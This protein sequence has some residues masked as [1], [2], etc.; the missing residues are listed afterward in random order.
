MDKASII[1]IV[2]AVIGLLGTVLSS[3]GIVMWFLNRKEKRQENRDSKIFEALEILMG[4]DIVIFDALRN[5][6]ING[7]SERQEEK[8]KEFLLNSFVKK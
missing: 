7:E 3:G 6:H 2:I 8:M 5:N 1:N 4:N